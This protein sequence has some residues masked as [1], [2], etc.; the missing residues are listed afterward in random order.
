MSIRASKSLSQIVG[1]TS[2]VTRRASLLFLT[3]VAVD[4][5]VLLY[6]P[7]VHKAHFSLVSIKTA[8]GSCWVGSVV[9][10]ILPFM[11]NS[12]YD[13]MMEMVA[14]QWDM[15]TMFLGKG[16]DRMKMFETHKKQLIW[17][18]VICEVIPILFPAAFLLVSN[19]VLTFK[20]DLKK[21]RDVAK[22]EESPSKKKY[23]PFSLKTREFAM[24]I[25]NNLGKIYLILTTFYY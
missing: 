5:V 22:L 2:E 4:Q 10:G 14:P 1:F 6:L 24:R 15:M 23:D 20:M 7:S 11:S 25:A 3:I 17:T 12:Q 21:R 13:L 8:V 16:D 19:I 9:F 18:F